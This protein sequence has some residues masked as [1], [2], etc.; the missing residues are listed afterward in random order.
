MELPAAGW[1]K[2]CRRVEADA[3]LVGGLTRD[4]VVTAH[5]GTARGLLA[6]LGIAKPAAAPLMDVIQ[7]V[8]YVIEGEKLT[9][10]A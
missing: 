4:T 10:F 8:V 1:R 7:G 3:R 2:L 9:R 6:A 5:G